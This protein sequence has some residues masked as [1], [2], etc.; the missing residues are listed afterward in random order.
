MYQGRPKVVITH[1]HGSL[2]LVRV[3]N[4]IPSFVIERR[5]V[6]CMEEGKWDKTPDI[7]MDMEHLLNELIDKK[8]KK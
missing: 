3:P 7:S 1:S 2:R 4:R 5:N 6:D 8:Q